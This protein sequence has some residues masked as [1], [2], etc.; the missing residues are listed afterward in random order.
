MKL[1]EPTEH[2]R[3]HLLRIAEAIGLNP[4]EILLDDFV[5]EGNTLTVNEKQYNPDGSIRMRER[6]VYDTTRR[7]YRLQPVELIHEDPA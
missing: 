5:L 6:G 3:Q 4:Q 2:G 1:P 7:T